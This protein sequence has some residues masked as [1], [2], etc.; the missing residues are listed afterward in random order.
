M[1]IGFGKLNRIALILSLLVWSM[2]YFLPAQEAGAANAKTALQAADNCRRGL[3]LSKEKMKFRDRWL[4]CIKQYEALVKHYPK[5]PEAG[6]ALYW[7]G[8]LYRDLYGQSHLAGDLDTA[9]QLFEQISQDYP[10]H[11]LADDAQYQIGEIYYREKKDYSKAYV[12]FL[13]IDVRFPDGDMSPKAQA[14]MEQLS[15]LISEKVEA[16][17]SKQT[18]KKTAPAFTSTETRVTGL[19]HI[20]TPTYTR[21]V[22]EVDKPVKYD[23]NV[24]KADPNHK[25]PRRLYLDLKDTYVTADMDSHIPIRDGLLQAAR[26]GQYAKGVVRVVLD[27]QNIGPYKIF[28]LYDPFRIVVD[29][30]GNPKPEPIQ[31]VKSKKPI[32]NGKKTKSV[33]GS[34]KGVQKG[35]K[36]ADEPDPTSTIVSQLGLN[37]KKIVIDPGHGGK[38]P[39]CLFDDN[40]K[41][42]D[43]VLTLAHILKK[44]IQEK[45]PKCEVVLTR[46]KDVFVQLDERTGI[47][48]AQKADLFISLHVN[49]HKQS[50]ISGL[51]TYF[52]NIA[53]DESAMSTAAKEN[54][55]SEKNISDLQSILKDLMLNTNIRESSKLAYDIQ[56]GMLNTLTP[57]FNPVKDLGVKQAPFY[58]L[59]GA[60]MPGILLEVGFITNP[61]ERRRLQSSEYLETLASGIVVGIRE[62]R[63]SITQAS[64]EF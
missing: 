51:E 55:T 25:K 17:W 58:V 39:G 5:M 34:N 9:I 26:A 43:I 53:T 1:K 15:T 38:D 63:E 3:Y 57:G 48:N 50:S 32:Q 46:D 10:E 31:T 28:P 12:E 49:A 35:T 27:I 8:K 62:Y 40:L 52:L 60:E 14:M 45:I 54:A 41:E 20:S 11:R 29:V 7:E 36:K 47:A 19:R 6:S 22:I 2:I 18:D 37:V 33:N 23:F 59:I 21:V 44:K 13:K 16:N 30:S 56:K 64:A 42:K 24:L 4:H 61:V